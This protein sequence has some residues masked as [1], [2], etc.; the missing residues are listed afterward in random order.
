MRRNKVDFFRIQV[1][2]DRAIVTR[3][4]Q[5]AAAIQLRKHISGEWLLALSGIISILFGAT[6]YNP[7]AGALAVIWLIGPYAVVFGILLLAFDIKLGGLERS[8]AHAVP[9]PV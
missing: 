6:L 9:T 4:F 5:I 1:S 7:V 2:S 8:L 3:A